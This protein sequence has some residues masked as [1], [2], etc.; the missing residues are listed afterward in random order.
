MCQMEIPTVCGS[1]AGSLI[2]V[3]SRDT[4]QEGRLFPEQIGE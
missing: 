3:N 1:Y 4:P 2:L